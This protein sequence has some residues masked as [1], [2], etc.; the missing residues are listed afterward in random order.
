[1]WYLSSF[2]AVF[3]LL[4]SDVLLEFKISA[5]VQGQNGSNLPFEV[6][7]SLTFDQIRILVAEKLWC[8]PGLLQ[9]CYHLDTDKRTANATSIQSEDK[10]ELFMDRMRGLIVP[11]RL[12]SGRIS[13]QALKP[14]TVA[15]EDGANSDN[16]RQ[17]SA[18]TSQSGGNKVHLPHVI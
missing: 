12:P 5:I 14:V 11:Q 15:F 13:A 7:S 1:M 4:T 16:S 3:H 6:Q 2:F 17:N 8:F 10:Y 9:L 18:K